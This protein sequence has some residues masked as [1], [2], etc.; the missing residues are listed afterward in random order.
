MRP[1]HLALGPAIVAQLKQQISDV[2]QIA[3][4]GEMSDVTSG[5]QISPSL[6]V[7][8]VRDGVPSGSQS[9][10]GMNHIVQQWMVVVAVQGSPDQLIA[11]A[12]QLLAR[13]RD[14]MLGWTPDTALYDPLQAATPPAA[15]YL[16]DWGYF[17]LMFNA[18]FYA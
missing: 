6:Y 7:I 18:D 4:R 12:G 15:M 14:A 2:R 9:M 16:S 11:K 8:Y 17:P 3:L 5:E 10:D 1:D 13:V